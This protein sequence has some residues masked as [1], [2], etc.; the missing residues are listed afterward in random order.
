M[1][2]Y[3]LLAIVLSSYLLYRCKKILSNTIYQNIADVIG[4]VVAAAGS[5]LML[6]IS[7]KLIPRIFDNLLLQI[8]SVITIALLAFLCIA[9]TFT[10]TCAPLLAKKIG[11]MT[12]FAHPSRLSSLLG[13]GLNAIFLLC[14]LLYIFVIFGVL[15]ATQ[16]AE[17]FR[18]EV[19]LKATEGQHETASKMPAFIDRREGVLKVME[20][21]HTFFRKLH[22]GFQKTRDFL[23]EKTGAKALL[24]QIRIVKKLSQLS[25]EE[26]RWLIETTPALR[27]L[28]NNPSL[29]AIMNDE[30]VM[31]L[32]DEASQGSLAALYHLGEEPLIK[33]LFDDKELVKTIK[34]I[35]LHDL[36]QKVKH[37]FL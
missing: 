19:S 24:E 30:Q 33:N 11:T 34:Q 37:H 27:K 16:N 25:D 26:K 5:S 10:R 7:K 2:V 23:V 9:N 8:L 31:T 17:E 18:G 4:F 13:K 20:A 29:F 1:L 28:A 15:T 36:L 12:Y 22:S 14:F 21:Q 32:I 35:R 6:F 3:G